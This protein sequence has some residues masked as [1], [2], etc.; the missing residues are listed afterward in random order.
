MTIGVAPEFTSFLRPINFVRGKIYD[1]VTYGV[2]DVFIMICI[3]M[4][5]MTMAMAFEGSKPD[6]DGILEKINLFFTSVFIMETSFKIIAFGFSE[7][8]SSGWNQFDFF[9]V[10]SS[11]L[12]LTL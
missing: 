2:F 8:W 9:V 4:N 11:I 1:L 6:Y 5:I 10:A 3:V 7:F 12:D